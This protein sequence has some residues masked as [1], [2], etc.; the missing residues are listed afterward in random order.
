VNILLTGAK[1][2]LGRSLIERMPSHFIVHA[3]SREELDITNLPV[4]EHVLNTIRPD[5][6]INT[7]A[8][9]AVDYAETDIESA[10]AINTL[11]VSYLA[12]FSQKLA[13]PLIHIS[14]DYVFDGENSD[15][16][17][18]NSDCNP[19]S[20]YGTT[21]RAG[22]IEALTSPFATVIRTSWLFSEHGNNFVKTMLKLGAKLNEL[23]IVADQIG[24]PTY[25]GD[26]A[27]F[28]ID[29]LTRQ[30]YQAGIYHY[31]GAEA[32][33]WYEFAEYIFEVATN[34]DGY[35]GMPILKRIPSCKY[36]TQAKRPANVIM[37]TEKISQLG[38]QPSYWKLRLFPVVEAI[39]Q[40]AL[41]G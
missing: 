3:F 30:E 31:C 7:A 20:V 32:V 1:G 17:Y 14:T 2:Q 27:D 25:A 29:L 15:P 12:M 26:L 11:A 33:S 22:E 6:I 5:A 40:E 18:E 41:R 39:I 35:R 21:K 19:L 13:I 34:L 8:Y 16:Y 36:P 4:L 23:S 38:Y 24:C 37:S 10:Q 9:T 28:I